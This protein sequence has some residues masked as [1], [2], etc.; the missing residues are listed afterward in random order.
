VNGFLQR[1]ALLAFA[2]LALSGCI[3]SSG[4]ILSDSQQAFGPRLRVQLFTL[5]Q[6][7]ARDPEQATFVWNGSLYTHAG[8][9]MREVAA[10][11]VNPFEGGDFI[12]QEVS[13]K[14]PRI[15]EYALAHKLVD[16]VYQ[17][18]AIDEADADEPTRAAFCG[19]GGPKDAAS[20]RITTREQLLA[21]ARATAARRRQDG[22]LAVLLSAEPERPA[23][24][25]R[26][27][28]R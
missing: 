17:V 28:R 13:V 9:A 16:G 18:L 21:F 14:R 25:H 20:C 4:P 5:H 11:S 15:A 22:G 6:G 19:K 2:G 10:F 12:L 3:D 26:R 7:F 8:G 23:R 24:H 1:A 27:H